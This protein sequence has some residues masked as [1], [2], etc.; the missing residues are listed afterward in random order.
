V[1]PFGGVG[2]KLLQANFEAGDRLLAEKIGQ[3][4]A[5]RGRE[6]GQVALAEGDLEVAALGDFDRVL[7]RFGE[8]GKQARPFRR[9]T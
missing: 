4:H 5:R 7:E 2:E 6:I 9:S 3:R 1:R 8:V